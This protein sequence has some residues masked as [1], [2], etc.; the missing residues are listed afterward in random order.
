[1][2]VDTTTRIES[3]ERAIRDIIIPAIDPAM[4]N[5]VEQAQY[6]LLHLGLMCKHVDEE[7]PFELAELR[8]YRELTATLQSILGANVSA[9][10]GAEVDCA[11][12]DSAQLAAIQLPSLARVRQQ[13]LRVRQTADSLLRI[14][15]AGSE[16]INRAATAAVFETA[17]LREVQDN[18]WAHGKGYES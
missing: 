7:Y 1:M 16:E 15:L 8:D 13:I 14:A 3:L 12:Q 17:Q 9:S 18:G 10:L 11:L 4:S 5:A 6:V 2:L